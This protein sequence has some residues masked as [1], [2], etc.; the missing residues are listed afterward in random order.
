MACLFFYL[1]FIFFNHGLLDLV[2][3]FQTLEELAQ[4]VGL[5]QQSRLRNVEFPIPGRRGGRH[6]VARQLAGPELREKLV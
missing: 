3:L 4:L 5:A 1:F 6:S 2:Q